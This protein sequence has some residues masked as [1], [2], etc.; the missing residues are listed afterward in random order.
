MSILQDVDVI[1]KNA[2]R[3]ASPDEA[4]K[5]AIKRLSNQNGKTVLVAVGK[6]AWQM[7]ATAYEALGNRVSEGIVVTKHGYAQGPIGPLAIVE[8]GHPVPDE[9]S[10]AAAD[11]A[12]E[13]VEPLNE[14]DLVLFLVSGG[15][16]ALFE[17]TLISEEENKEITRQLLACGANIAEINTLRKRLSAVKGGKFAKICAPAKIFSIV[18]S[19][20]VGDSLDMIASGPAYPD[21]STCE[22]ALAIVKKYN[23][24]LSQKALELLR[25]ET[26]KVLEGVETHITG[27]VR[28]LCVSAERTCR[29]LGY[30]SLILT[31]RLCCEAKE[32]GGFLASIA[33]FHAESSRSLAFIAGGET[34]VRLTGNGL[35]GRNQE[36]A[37]SA[38][39][40]ISGV[41][42]CA[43]FSVGSDGTDGPTD[44]AGAVCTGESAK[45]L[46]KLGVD[47]CQTLRDNDS[48]NALKKIGALIFTGP[49]G[50][51]VNDLSCVLI[52]R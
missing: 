18:L 25:V 3:A 36:I 19:D 30:E 38:A 48:Y 2:I 5:R 28:E 13:L 41:R 52:K 49:T 42:D 23:L 21:A 17:K 26:P 7:A 9:N 33:R 46:E 24:T 22:Q 8:A 51:N 4:V 35:G 20:V 47:I 32:A 15:G 14:Q 29:E 27:S 31:D 16:S 1:V 6:A 12:I 45:K 43:V 10:Y 44:A 39:L 40:G 37:L 11:Q 34:I 50:T